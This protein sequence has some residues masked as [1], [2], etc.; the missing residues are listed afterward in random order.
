MLILSVS[1]VMSSALS[2]SFMVMFG[3]SD[4]G[5]SVIWFYTDEFHN[6]F[7]HHVFI[8]I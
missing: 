4:Q 3:H 1:L 5:K 2:K 6:D 7:K 8:Y